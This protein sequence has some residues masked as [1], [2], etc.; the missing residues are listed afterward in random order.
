MLSVL[1]FWLSG[2]FA[3]IMVMAFIIK[4]II[5]TNPQISEIFREKEAD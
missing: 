1:C 5:E 3:G 2:F 4:H